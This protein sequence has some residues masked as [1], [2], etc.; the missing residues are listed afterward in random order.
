[1]QLRYDPFRM[2]DAELDRMV[3]RTISR[4]QSM[5][6]DAYRVEDSFIVELDLPGVAA[7]SIDVMVDS[8]VL[9]IRA[10]RPAE[11]VEGRQSLISERVHGSFSRELYLGQGLDT[12]AVTAS[13]TDGVLRV[14][15]PVAETAKPRR[16]SVEAG[17][18]SRQVG[19]GGQTVDVTS[20]ENAH[21]NA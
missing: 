4:V 17:G 11:R 2:L 21:A 12:T 7:D 18:E 3:N 9:R 8:D 16:I 20:S 13:Y 1:M 10:E 14:T 15:L 6:I 5:P 19:A